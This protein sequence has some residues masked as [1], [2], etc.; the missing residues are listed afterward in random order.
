MQDD[1]IAQ[2]VELMLV[3]M[4]T[5]FAFLTVLVGATSLM[6]TLVMRRAAV[7]AN[8]GGPSNEELA[9]MSAAIARHR[10]K[11]TN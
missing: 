11:S 7:T 3:G 2:G 8:A 4:G 6:S 10:R 9:A 1:L 5:V